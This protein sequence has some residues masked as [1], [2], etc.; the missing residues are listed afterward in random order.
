MH[1]PA[2]LSPDSMA[3]SLDK[4]TDN[5]ESVCLRKKVLGLGFPVRGFLAGCGK[6]PF[7]CSPAI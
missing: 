5:P 3:G 2:M 7:G 4:K 6:T 1:I